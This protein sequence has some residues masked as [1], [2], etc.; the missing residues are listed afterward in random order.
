MSFPDSPSL[1]SVPSEQKMTR[2]LSGVDVDA[3]LSHS[4]KPEEISG[5]Q[6][7][8]RVKELLRWFSRL[9]RQMAN[10][11][12]T[13]PHAYELAYYIATAAPPA[14]PISVAREPLVFVCEGCGFIS[15]TTSEHECSAPHKAFLGE[16]LN[17]RAKELGIS[18]DDLE[19]KI[20]DWQGP[21]PPA[22]SVELEEAMDE[23]I[24]TVA[25]PYI[26]HRQQ[27]HD[28]ARF[29]LK[30]IFSKMVAQHEWEKDCVNKRV[31]AEI[32]TYQDEL[33]ALRSE[34]AELKTRITQQN[35]SHARRL[36]E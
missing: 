20:G 31:G 26:D 9:T 36:S 7:E 5:E 15:D 34:V 16:M 29:S 2:N 33:S 24:H 27:A 12:W 32:A 1:P 19:K 4:L 6:R 22:I 17:K 11:K 35:H 14:V 8:L 28:A 10:P 13:V 21:P 30:A 18:R 25:S 3:L 23:L